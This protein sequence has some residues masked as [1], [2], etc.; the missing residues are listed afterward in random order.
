MKHIDSD[1]RVISFDIGNTL[2]DL[3]DVPGFCTYFCQTTN[4]KVDD[5]RLLLN[6]YFLKRNADIDE[7]VKEI[8]SIIG[9]DKYSHIIHGY[10]KKTAS[11]YPD[12]LP[13]LARLK[14]KGFML[15]ACSNCVKW[16]ADDPD[17]VL[18]DSLDNIFYSYEIG[19]AKPELGFFKFVS[20]AINIEASRILHIGDSLR[21]DY[22][23]AREAGWNAMLLDRRH[24][25]LDL[26]VDCIHSL[27]E[28]D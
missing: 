1:I 17:G 18:H 8:C 7:S 22:Y 10:Q 5:I 25:Y 27:M 4:R 13:T 14:N 20:N 23:A 26:C 28:L 16:D 21:A 19:Y 6:N 9:I 11:L 15:I 2:I 12:V 3:E 24:K